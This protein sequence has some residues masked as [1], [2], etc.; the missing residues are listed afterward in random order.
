MESDMKRQLF[1]AT[2]FT[3]LVTLNP[4]ARA[5]QIFNDEVLVQGLCASRAGACVNGE[6]FFPAALIGSVAYKSKDNRTGIWF[7]DTDAG[8][9]DWIIF[10][11]DLADVTT[12]VP[13]AFHI[14][15]DESD[16]IP[17]IIENGAGTNLLYLDAAER[18]GINTNV[19]FETLD[20]RTS[21]PGIRLDDTSAGAGRVDLDMDGNLFWI[22]GNTDQGIVK[23]DTRAPEHSLTIDSSGDVGIGTINPAYTVDVVG[24]RILLRNSANTRQILMRVDGAAT[25]LEATNADLFLRSSTLGKNIVMNPFGNDGNVA[26]G[27]TIPTAK[28]H[29]LDSSTSQILVENTDAADGPDRALFLLKDASS[30]KIRFL[31]QSG[32]GTW[33]FDNAGIGFQINK[34]GTGVNEFRVEADGDIV[35][36]GRSFATQHINTSS[37]KAKTGFTQVDEKQILEQLAALPISQWRY[38]TEDQDQTHVGPVA[39]DF[40]QVFGLSDGA[41]ISTVDASGVVMAAVKG[42]YQVVKEKDAE[43]DSLKQANAAFTYANA[44]LEERLARLESLLL[45][46]KH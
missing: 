11:D 40:Q 7:D 3:V 32:N 18:I 34:V 44:M 24:N 42:L 33:S 22:Q 26:I 29:V 17:L 14:F 2:I 1:Y 41:H 19:P 25:D 21:Q 4:S 6:S 9:A 36:L 15:N 12:D 30:N 38:K 43:L 35:A 20:I 31:I 45:V 13:E 8:D 39:E 27:T 23:M 37:R 10:M 28:L 5:D 16:S 46:E